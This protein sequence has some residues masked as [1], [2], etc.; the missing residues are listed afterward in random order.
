MARVSLVGLPAVSPPQLDAMSSE[1][2]SRDRSQEKEKRAP[3]RDWQAWAR[4][5]RPECRVVLREGGGLSDSSGC[6]M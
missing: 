1:P 3:D 4:D 6:V 5:G 2:E